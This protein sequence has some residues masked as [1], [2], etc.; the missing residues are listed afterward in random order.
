[1]ITRAKSAPAQSRSANLICDCSQFL[2]WN[3]TVY[4]IDADRRI[5]DWI[6]CIIV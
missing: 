5:P 1:M 2:D 4:S 6:T 3:S